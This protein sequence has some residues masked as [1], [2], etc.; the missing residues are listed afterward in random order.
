MGLP[1]N[2]YESRCGK[3]GLFALRQT[4]KKSCEEAKMPLV[5]KMGKENFSWNS[6]ITDDA[7]EEGKRKEGTQLPIKKV[8]Q[9]LSFQNAF[10]PYLPFVIQRRKG[11]FNLLANIQFAAILFG[12]EYRRF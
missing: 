10:V 2:L 5:E 11:K 12:K 6:P 3:R 8:D 9:H 1:W 7:S 4:Q